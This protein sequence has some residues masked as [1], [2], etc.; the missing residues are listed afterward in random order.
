M[1]L[2]EIT[3]V[4]AV[5]GSG[6]L[7][8]SGCGKDQAAT[9]VPSGSSASD[10]GESVCGAEADPSPVDEEAGEASCDVAGGEA[11]DAPDAGGDAPDAGEAA[12]GE[13][14]CA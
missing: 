7:L 10:P 4:L 3:T 12:C 11:E 14:T 13:G 9:E 5:L 8:V 6:S 1:N 2:K